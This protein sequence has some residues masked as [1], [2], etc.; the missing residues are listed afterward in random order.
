MVDNKLTHDERKLKLESL[1]NDCASSWEGI[2]GNSS[3]ARMIMS[4]D[5]DRKFCAMYLMETYHYTKHN[6]RNQALVGVLANNIPDSYRRFCFHH[7]EEE[8]GHENMALHDMLSSLGVHKKDVT[9][10]EPLPATEVL[11]AYLYYASATGNPYQRLGYSFW[12]EACYEYINPL[13]DMIREKLNLQDN[14]MTFFKAH[15]EIDSEHAKE[16]EEMLVH[17]CQT[18][19][20]WA[21]VEKVMKT[22][23][24][25]TAA[26]VEGVV[27]AYIEDQKG[28]NKYSFLNN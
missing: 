20:D 5:V 4:G 11:V 1:R 2:L 27:E 17:C 8:T 12:A 3:M 21:A 9:L 6:A 24:K 25:L 15:S 16:V 14:Q 23:L 26:M 18:E 10:P 22:S 7:A 28:A 13:I 19:A